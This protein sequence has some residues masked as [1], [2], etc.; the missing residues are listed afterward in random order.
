MGWFGADRAGWVPSVAQLGCA[1]FFFVLIHFPISVF[2]I[3]F[4]IFCKYAS[5]QFNPLS[6]IF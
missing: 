1:P 6:E 2:S 4:Y 3:F 5:N